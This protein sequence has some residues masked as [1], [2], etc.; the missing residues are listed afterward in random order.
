M[1]RGQVWRSVVVEAGIVGLAGAL[2]GVG[3]GLVIGFV[4]VALAGGRVDPAS[5]VPWAIVAAAFVLGVAVAMLAAAY[6]AHI[7]SRISIVRAVQYE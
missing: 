1:T 5:I 4:M 6:P 3:A 7:A 2:M